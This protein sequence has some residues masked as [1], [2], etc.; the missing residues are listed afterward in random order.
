MCSY[1]AGVVRSGVLVAANMRYREAC[2]SLGSDG[3]EQVWGQ[4]R[5]PN[6]IAP[7]GRVCLLRIAY[8]INVSCFQS[9][10]SRIR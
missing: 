3:S 1:T 7:S 4:E 5:V 10:V 6:S 2:H 8:T 9:M